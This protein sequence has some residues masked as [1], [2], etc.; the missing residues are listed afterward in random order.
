M[1]SV[2]CHP[3]G[4][5]LFSGAR[6]I[7]ALPTAFA[8][9]IASMG[10]AQAQQCT[11]EIKE[12][13][14]LDADEPQKNVSIR[15]CNLAGAPS[16]DDPSLVGAPD[17]KTMAW[18]RHER[19][20]ECIW[21]PQCRITLRSGA[22]ITKEDFPTITD[23][24]TSVGDAGDIVIHNCGADAG[25]CT[26]ASAFDFDLEL[27]PTFQAC[28]DQWEDQESGILAISL[29][30]FLDSNGNVSGF[31][32]IALSNAIS[33]PSFAMID[34]TQTAADNERVLAHEVGHLLTLCHTNQG[35]C[36][37]DFPGDPNLLMRSN[38]PNGVLTAEQCTIARDFLDDNP[39]IDQP[40]M[41]FMQDP[42][43]LDLASL[44]AVN[45]AVG[46]FPNF[47]GLRFLDIFRVMVIDD[48]EGEDRLRFVVALSDALG[49]VPALFG[50]MLDIDNDPSTGVVPT[51][52]VAGASMDGV[53]L[54]LF[55]QASGNA[56]AGQPSAFALSGGALLPVPGA[57]VSAFV[58]E[59]EVSALG[60]DEE[61]VDVPI[62]DEIV[63]DVDLSGLAA[64]GIPTS[65]AP[66][67]NGLRIQA[68]SQA[69]EGDS[70]VFSDFGPN[71]A[72]VMELPEPEYPGMSLEG[73]GCAGDTVTV[74]LSGM[75]PDT[76]LK[77]VLGEELFMPVGTT[78]SEGV[79]IF[80]LEIPADA[81][82]GP[83]LLTVGAI[84]ADNAVTGDL[85]VDICP[86]ETPDNEGPMEYT[87]KVVCGVQQDGGDTGFAR[88]F[89]ATTVNIRN[90]G[91][92][93][94]RVRKELALA[95][96]P[97]GQKPG[98]VKRISID[99]L[100]ARAAMASDCPDIKAR[101]F[102]NGF[103]DGFIDGFLVLQSNMPLD[104]TSVH[105]LATLSRNGV[106]GDPV[107]VDVERIEGR[108]LRGRSAR[109]PT[110]N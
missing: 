6:P 102:P 59:I 41:E 109:G 25:P 12:A 3:Y 19:A 94:A 88:G 78:D 89:Y 27:I 29:G 97:G 107:S 106:T 34:P 28:A 99:E 101:V 73:S 108:P 72:V 53:D 85:I 21:I 105:S 55:V 39:Q 91:Q 8:I 98:E 14:V 69:I 30:N 50:V 42:D 5:G 84:D 87:A 62:F 18:R 83:T 32:G 63:I 104:V 58:N 43:I 51:P 23:I 44:D 74:S 26:T 67:P 82:T 52:P 75:T 49:P 70:G 71:A 110:G 54:V 77:A 7:P 76:E 95:R 100:P 66:F 37:T 22:G 15:W 11:P 96:P 92:K 93:T 46:E 103:P 65:G 31:D 33:L 81:A 36:A 9:I 2:V 17:A 60:V 4:C 45:D 57:Q 90:A 10:M 64:L 16:V 56:G 80:P 1:H 20:S 86:G 79:A 68:F 47:P 24:D 38:V 35:D 61:G 40:L 13:P 48:L